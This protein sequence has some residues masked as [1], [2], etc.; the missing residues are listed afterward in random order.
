MARLE[1]VDP[2]KTTGK[3]KQLLDGMQAKLGVIPNLM[4][5]MAAAPA[6]LDAYVSLTGALSGGTLSHKLREQIALAIAEQNACDYC[7]AAHSAIGR[8]VGLSPQ[9]LLDSRRGHAAD[10][11]VDAL[12]GFARR[13]VEAR[14]HVSDMDVARVKEHGWSDGE[15]GEVIA[16]VALSLFT[17]YYNHV[18]QTQIDFPA[19]EPLTP[20]T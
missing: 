19:A 18:A 12:L 11:R 4:R 20:R 6:V 3:T 1:A 13:V 16:N 10:A 7:V 9:E 14:G 2:A 5:T 15:I 8:K 17:N